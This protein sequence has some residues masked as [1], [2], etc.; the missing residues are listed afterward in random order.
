[1]VKEMSLK[2]KGMGVPFFGTRSELVRIGAKDAK[3]DAKE[4]VSEFSVDGVVEE[5]KGVIDEVDLIKLQR[6]MLGILE[7]LCEG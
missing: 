4:G 6:K 2:L 5:K 7:D 1:M 3:G